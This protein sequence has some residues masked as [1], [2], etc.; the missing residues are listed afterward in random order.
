MR[1]PATLAEPALRP[2]KRIS[3]GKKRCCDC[4]LFDCSAFL[5]FD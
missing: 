1:R 2:Q 4:H 5:P 3:L